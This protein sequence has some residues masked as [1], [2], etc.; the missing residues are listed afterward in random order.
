MGLDQC[1][2]ILTR[3]IAMEAG[4]EELRRI[5]KKDLSTDFR[6]DFAGGG[7]DWLLPTPS[8]KLVGPV[9]VLASDKGSQLD[10]GV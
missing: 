10:E 3:C 6:L 2:D 8:D 1:L 7:L 9:G 4:D 5:S